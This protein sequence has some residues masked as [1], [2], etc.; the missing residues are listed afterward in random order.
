MMMVE[1]MYRKFKDNIISKGMITS[2]DKV[3]VALSGG[4]D[5]VCLLYLMKKLGDDIGISVSALHVNHMLRGAESDADEKFCKKLCSSLDIALTC[6]IEDVKKYSIDNK[7]TLEE[8]GR[9]VRYK[10][11]SEIDADRIAIA[12]NMDDNAETFLMNLMR[13][14]GLNGL[15][16]IPETS[17]RL[18]RPL[19]IFR[20]HEIV[21]YCNREGLD[22]RTDSSNTDTDFFRNAVRH[23]LIP[24]MNELSGKEVVGLI[25]RTAGLVM[26][27][28]D[29]IDEQAMLAF[30]QCTEE[31]GNSVV[32]D[33]EMFSRLHPTIAARVVR[34]AF[35]K[36]EGSLKDFE[37]KNTDALSDM[38]RYGKTGDS[39]D[40]SSD[41]YAIVQFGKTILSS[42]HEQTDY[43]Y[44][45]EIPGTI[46]IKER[47]L[48]LDFDSGEFSDNCKGK[49]IIYLTVPENCCVTVRNRRDGDR[50][51][52]AGGNG[53]K[54]LKKYFIEHKV[55]RMNRNK[56]FLLE[57]DGKIAYIEGMDKGRDF[58]PSEGNNCIILKI[59][60][61]EQ[62]A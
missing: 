15:K 25:D 49:E 19:M 26:A 57:I 13:G 29:F 36:K 30:E 11:L 3:L 24:V 10:V 37:K 46:H 22:F 62:D 32:L 43:E 53:T 6:H 4:A 35:F 8:A 2:G 20:K 27:D 41:T 44:D 48:R 7:M 1:S 9:I 54:K 14:T 42:R 28:S 17:G 38:I 31:E 52:P 16:G 21:D 34:K 61:G 5:S 50:F 39:M 47:S 23:R 33:N 60:R 56:L 59:E 51:A 18:I 58:V 45:V 12:H 55:P 40:L